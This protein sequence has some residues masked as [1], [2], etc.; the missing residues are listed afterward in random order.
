MS[1]YLLQASG[2]DRPGIIEELTLTLAPHG[3]RVLDVG[4]AVIHSTVN[5]GLLLEVSDAPSSFVPEVESVGRRLGLS[6]AL[7]SI[8]ADDYEHWVERQGDPR[9][10]ITVFGPALS[11][12]H[13]A[14][15]SSM[16]ARHRLN[17]D[18]VTR[19]SGRVSL[20]NPVP[21]NVCLEF[22][23]R[24]VPNDPSTLRQ[25]LLVAAQELGCDI[26]IQADDMYRRN[27]RMIAFDMDST[28]IQTEVI[29]ELARRHGVVEKVAAITEAA[30]NG[31]L[32]FDQSLRRRLG[33]LEGLSAD[34]LEEIAND[35]PIT[36]GAHR[37]IGTVRA[38]G[39]KTAILSGGFTYFGQRLQ[40]LL[41]IDY[42]YANELEIKD[43]K[44]T[45]GVLGPIVNGQ[46]KAQLLREIADQESIK[47]EQVIA[48]GD[49]ANDVPMLN[50]AGLGIAFHAKPKVRE[51][52][53]QQISTVGLDGVLYLIGV[54]DRDV[55]RGC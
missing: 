42:V 24:G 48:V 27:R 10:I 44:L 39:Y 30:M 19:L 7:S 11:G 5:L 3:V 54:R 25:E 16:V 51:S 2:P 31:E 8:S 34:V 33:L 6:V 20:R 41:G 46:R 53:D 15:I 1:I 50:A 47:L 18:L 52:T 9:W 28:L 13:L 49:G 40:T 21:A 4:Q 45:G 37:L 32:D 23:L 14:R 22:T 38:M 26:A 55:P 12:E 29:D 43:G 36:P 17:V 35:L